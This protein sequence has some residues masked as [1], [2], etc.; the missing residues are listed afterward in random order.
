MFLV[1]FV[2]NQLLG[3]LIFCRGFFV[4]VVV[5]VVVLV[6]VCFLVPF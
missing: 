3:L 1:D 4:V 2:K 5:V 6:V